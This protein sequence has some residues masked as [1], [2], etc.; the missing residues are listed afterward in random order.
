MFLL[1][2][3]LLR[4]SKS[5]ANPTLKGLFRPNLSTFYIHVSLYQTRQIVYHWWPH[6][7][8]ILFYANEATEIYLMIFLRRNLSGNWVILIISGQ[9]FEEEVTFTSISNSTACN[10]LLHCRLNKHYDR[11]HTGHGSCPEL[12]VVCRVGYLSL[13]YSSHLS[14]VLQRKNKRKYKQ[15]NKRFVK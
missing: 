6:D 7:L 8:K 5:G 4:F 15:T 2:Q 13:Q 12:P 14:R 1:N 3:Y 10:C 9:K 11:R